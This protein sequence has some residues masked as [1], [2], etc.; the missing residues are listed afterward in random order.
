M[1]LYDKSSQTLEQTLKSLRVIQ[2]AGF[3]AA[4][5]VAEKTPGVPS[6]VSSAATRG[7][8]TCVKSYFTLAQRVLDAER[9]TAERM[10]SLNKA[11]LSPRLR[12]DKEVP[13]QAV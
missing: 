12:T 1:S 8:N 7:T 11:F 2:D 4:A 6:L 3:N 13:L 5:A 9:H 10:L